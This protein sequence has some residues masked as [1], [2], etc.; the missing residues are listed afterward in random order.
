MVVDD[1][2][3]LTGDDDDTIAGDDDDTTVVDDDDTTAVDDD[4]TMAATCEVLVPRPSDLVVV[5]AGDMANFCDDFNAIN[6]CKIIIKTSY[7]PPFSGSL[8]K[9]RAQGNL[10]ALFADLKPG[11]SVAT[12]RIVGVVSVIRLGTYPSACSS[13]T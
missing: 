12:H 11:T 10:S 7:R 5:V 9:P 6:E 2:D 3:T 4:D 8:T 1:D 13:Q